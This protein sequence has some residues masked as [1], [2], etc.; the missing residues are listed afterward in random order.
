MH[1][2]IQLAVVY[3]CMPVYMYLH[4]DFYISTPIC[5]QYIYYP[6]SVYEYLLLTLDKFGE[7]CFQP[8]IS[9]RKPPNQP[10]QIAAAAPH[11]RRDSRTRR[12][13]RARNNRFQHVSF[14][15]IINFLFSIY[16][17]CQVLSDKHKYPFQ[18][19]QK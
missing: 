10:S 15:P 9:L 2:F 5:A 18:N 7:N 13:P 14:P 17:L 19:G 12:L 6:R 3:V 16:N 11:R 8:D 1:P 4:R